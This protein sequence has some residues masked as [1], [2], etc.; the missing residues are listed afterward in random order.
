MEKEFVYEGY[1]SQ[2]AQDFFKDNLEKEQRDSLAVMGFFVKLASG[3]TYM[4]NKGDVFT[5]WE[6]G[7]IT[8]K[9]LHRTY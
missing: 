2:E 9:S 1:M 3:K 5:K 4:P 8:V 7:S 6:N